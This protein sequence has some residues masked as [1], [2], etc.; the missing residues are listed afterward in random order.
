MKGYFTVGSR[1]TALNFI[2]VFLSFEVT[3]SQ[4]RVITLFING[5]PAIFCSVMFSKKFLLSYYQALQYVVLRRSG[6]LV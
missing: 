3:I 1:Y 4:T 2:R 5:R 6:V